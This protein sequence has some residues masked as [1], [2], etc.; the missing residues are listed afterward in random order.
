MKFINKSEAC[1]GVGRA[2]FEPGVFDISEPFSPEA[3]AALEYFKG[4]NIVEVVVATD[5]TESTE[6]EAESDLPV[7]RTRIRTKVKE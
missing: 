6:E 4:L 2:N 5:P 1:I 3:A 7:T